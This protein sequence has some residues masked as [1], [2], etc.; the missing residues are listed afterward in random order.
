MT[1]FDAFENPVWATA[2]A[3]LQAMEAGLCGDGKYDPAV[4]ECYLRVGQRRDSIG[5]FS[6]FDNYEGQVRSLRR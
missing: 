5:R 3:G 4:T 2:S 6:S 1:T